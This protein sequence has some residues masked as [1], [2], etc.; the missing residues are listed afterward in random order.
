M[1]KNE[2]CGWDGRG[3]YD[4]FRALGACKNTVLSKGSFIIDHQNTNMLM[5]YR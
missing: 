2:N 1:V 3:Q 5:I 4:L